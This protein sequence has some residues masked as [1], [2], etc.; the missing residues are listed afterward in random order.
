M[1]YRTVKVKA[2][3]YLNDESSSYTSLEVLKVESCKS[4]AVIEYGSTQKQ[5][6]NCES[7]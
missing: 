4:V 3:S 5:T 6:S 7:K 1:I 2:S